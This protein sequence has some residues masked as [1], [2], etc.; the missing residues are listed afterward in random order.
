[1]VRW[2]LP[3]PAG[4]RGGPVAEALHVCMAATARAA[5]CAGAARRT[6]GGGLAL[7]PGARGVHQAGTGEDGWTHVRS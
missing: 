4:H 5:P 6:R 7:P 1:M 3:T 2:P